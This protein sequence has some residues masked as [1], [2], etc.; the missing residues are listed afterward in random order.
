MNYLQA[1][2]FGI[3][4][5]KQKKTKSYNLDSELLLA[6]VLN[7]TREEL[8]INLNKKIQKNVFI[9]YK[10]LIKRRVKKEPIA[11]LL[12]KKEFWKYIFYVNKDVLIPRPE[13]ELIIEETLK[14]IRPESSKKLLD[15]GT[16]SGCIII[17]LINE[18][19][20]CNGIAID[21]SKK[22]LKI[23]K[24][25]AKMHHLQNKINFVNMNIDK[26]IDYKYDFIIS[27]PPY[28][29][30]QDL[31]RLDDDVSFYEPHL[32]LEAGVDGL[33]EIKKLILKSKHLLKTN[34]RL[35]FEIGK[36]QMEYSKYLLKINGFR[37]NK[38]S[39]DLNL[40]PRIIVATKIF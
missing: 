21:I 33:R 26:F 40:I 23:A 31:S 29:T 1:I 34:G 39:K 37:I 38:V 2:D 11:Y 32:A 30:K 16:G 36:D 12:K 13:T 17:S 28:I 6:K 35:I 5:L 9:K 27:N 20:K 15:V 14:I 22:A 18:R 19:P 8:L 4:S 25:N 3:N 10:K 24:F 7:L